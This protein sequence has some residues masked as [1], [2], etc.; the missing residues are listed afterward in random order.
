MKNLLAVNL[1]LA[2]TLLGATAQAQTIYPIDRAEIL[3]GSRFDLKVEF[4]GAPAQPPCASRSTARSAADV[5]GKPAT[6][7]ERED[8][9]RAFGLLDPRRR[10]RQARATTR[11]R[12]APATRRARHLGGLRDAERRRRR[13][14]SCSSATACRSRTAPPRACCRRAS[15]RAAMAASSPSTT[16]RTWRWSRPRAP[17]RSSPTAPTARA[18]TPPATSPASTR[19]ASIARA[20]RAI[21]IIRRSRRSPSWSSARAACRSASSPTPRSR[22]RRRPRWWR[23]TACAPTTTTS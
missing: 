23:T 6:F 14:S 17:T 1:A 16:C 10:D 15:R 12:R 2:S 21:S 19:S 20:T 9:A 7:V 8:G 18:P 3:A 22:M 4:P 5:A 13:T 11:S